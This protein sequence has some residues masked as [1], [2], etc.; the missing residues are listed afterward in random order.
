MSSTEALRKVTAILAILKDSVVGCVF[1]LKCDEIF[2]VDVLAVSPKYQGHHIGRQLMNKIIEVAHE[3]RPLRLVTD[4]YNSVAVSLY[5]TS[6]F[7]ILEPLSVLVGELKPG[8]LS[9]LPDVVIRRMTESDVPKCDSMCRHINGFSRKKEILSLLLPPSGMP[10]SS[11]IPHVLECNGDIVGYSCGLTFE[12]HT[13]CLDPKYFANILD[14]WKLLNG[15]NPLKIFFPV[16]LY[17][18]LEIMCLKA[19]LKHQKTCLLMGRGQYT[20]PKE[21]CFNIPSVVY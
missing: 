18:D 20:P 17:P 10:S 14:S 12:G 1:L 19:G 2:G 4:A 16:R 13:C 8:M 9:P 11:V 15:E 21:D 6:S 3:D 5:L 7:H